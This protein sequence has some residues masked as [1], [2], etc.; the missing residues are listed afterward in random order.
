ML[1]TEL[2]DEKIMLRVKDGQLADLGELFERYNVRMFNFF[3]KLSFD[4]FASEDMVQT[5]FYRL[6]KYRHTFKPGEGTFRPWIYQAAR[7]VHADFYKQQRRV[8]DKVKSVDEYHENIPGEETPY[9]DEDMEKLDKALLQLAP[10]QREIILLSRYEG[11]KY[12]EISKIMDI[13]VAAIKV[14]VHRAIK[15][16]RT[17]Y[18][19]QQ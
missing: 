6:I 10:A 1:A 2:T 7:N 12:E 19:T 18:F 17:I 11:L 15:Q 13:S 14:Q 3:L 8:N 16:L 5:L 9:R 4:R